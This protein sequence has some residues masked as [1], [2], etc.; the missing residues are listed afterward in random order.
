FLTR[1]IGLSCTVAPI[2][3]AGGRLCAALDVSTCRSDLTPAML[4]LI[5]AATNEAAHRIEASHFR[6]S[7][8]HARILV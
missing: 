5:A 8:R 4:K 6:E 1:N 2:H 7:F 3:D